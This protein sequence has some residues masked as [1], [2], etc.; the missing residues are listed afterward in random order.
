MFVFQT[1]LRNITQ[2]RK[3]IVLICFENKI[4]ITAHACAVNCLSSVVVALFGPLACLVY[5]FFVN[6]RV[7][8]AGFLYEF[9]RNSH[10]ES[11]VMYSRQGMR[12]KKACCMESS[13]EDVLSRVENFVTVRYVNILTEVLLKFLDPVPSLIILSLTYISLFSVCNS[14]TSPWFFLCSVL[15]R[16]V[17]LTGS[18]VFV[19]LIDMSDRVSTLFNTLQTA[20]V[21][22]SVLVIAYIIPND[23]RPLMDRTILLTTYIFVDVITDSFRKIDFGLPSSMIGLILVIFL[24]LAQT[25]LQQYKSMTFVIRS[26][27][28]IATNLIFGALAQTALDVHI[29]LAILAILLISIVTQISP[30]SEMWNQVLDY[31]VF[32]AAMELTQNDLPPNLAALAGVV[33]ITLRLKFDTTS[34]LNRQLYPLLDTMLLICINTIVLWVKTSLATN[35]NFQNALLMFLYI[36]VAVTM[37]H[38]ISTT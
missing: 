35:I 27:P 24:D 28:M 10:G 37:K 31:A 32:V 20:I 9:I 34:I 21:A 14:K 11:G 17:I 16:A 5:D 26:L 13:V 19:N 29:V 4:Q 15:M 1:L 2:G 23:T 33:I 36:M 38:I 22:L 12:Y 7:S 3:E 8:N 6:I 18:N 25:S 30:T